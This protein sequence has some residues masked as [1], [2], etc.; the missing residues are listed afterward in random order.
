[1]KTKEF[2]KKNIAYIVALVCNLALIGFLFAPLLTYRTRV[3]EGDNKI[4]TYFSVNIIKM[5]NPQVTERWIGIVTLSLF[6]II[7][8]LLVVSFLLKNKNRIHDAIITSNLII[9]GLTVCFLFV[10][11]EIFTNYAYDLIADFK[12]ASI[13]W[14]SAV[15]LFLLAIEFL[16][17]ISV[18][19]FSNQS[20]KGIAEDAILIA[21]AFVLNLVTLF[22]APTGGSINLQ[23]LPL[24][25][26]ALRRGPLPGF[27]CGGVIYGLMTCIS[28]GYGFATFPFDYLIG[29]GSAGILGFFRPLIFP[30]DENKFSFVKSELFLFLGGVLSTFV[31]FVGSTT[32][33]AVIYHLPLNEAMLYNAV[34]VPVSGAIAIVILMLLFPAIKIINK[35]FPVEHNNKQY[36]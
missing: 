6:A 31:R 26:I 11:K 8:I 17:L 2:L 20:M 28:D 12:D 19:S 23:M 7:L 3:Y 22:K 35:R 13:S 21:A 25:F 10:D 5:F 27:I 29:F 1:M 14:G 9:I 24:M 34:Y 16:C 32:S 33:S 36:Q 30:K 18:S 4:D 15:C